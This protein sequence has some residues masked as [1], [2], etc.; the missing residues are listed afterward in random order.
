MLA[1]ERQNVKLPLNIFNESTI[2]GLKIQNESRHPNSKTQSAEFVSIILHIWKIFSVCTPQ[3]G[4]RLND[5]LSKPLVKDDPRFLFLERIV[6]WIDAWEPITKN[7]KAS[8][9]RQ[10][11][12]SLRHTCLALPLLVY[13]LTNECGFAYVLASFYK[14]IHWNITSGYTDKQTI[15]SPTIKFLSLSEG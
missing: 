7:S 11:F 3:K 14:M 6:N 13:Y 12:T 2:A 10:T 9:T 5:D 8:L 1:L 4:T 15:I